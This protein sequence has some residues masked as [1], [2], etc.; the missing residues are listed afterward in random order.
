M[1]FFSVL[2]CL[3]VL[4]VLISSRVWLIFFIS[5]F[6]ATNISQMVGESPND[7]ND[8]G[9]HLS[10]LFWTEVTFSGVCCSFVI[11]RISFYYFCS[12]S[13]MNYQLCLMVYLASV[14]LDCHC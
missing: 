1:S 13:K 7:R 11:T 10:Y 4:T 12:T 2:S 14:I 5:L 9:R 3:F 8:R 6:R